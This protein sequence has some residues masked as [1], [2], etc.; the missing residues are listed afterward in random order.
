MRSRPGRCISNFAWKPTLGALS[1]LPVIC[2]GKPARSPP[3]VTSTAC[4]KYAAL[5]ET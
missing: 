5:P 2:T 1:A 4:A 3:V